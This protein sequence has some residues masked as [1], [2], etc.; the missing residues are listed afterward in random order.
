M[1]QCGTELNDGDDRV[2]SLRVSIMGRANKV[3]IPVQVCYR[4]PNQD[5]ETDE[6]FYKHLGEVSRSLALVL[7][8]DFHLPGVCWKYDTAKRKQV[9]EVPEKCGRDL[10]DTA[11][12]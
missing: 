7:M 2:E 5:E 12:Q 1:P 4:S 6:T 9:Q 10:P 8:G 3:G 11:G